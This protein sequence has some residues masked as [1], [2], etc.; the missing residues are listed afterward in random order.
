MVMT[1]IEMLKNSPKNTL[2]FINNELT[3]AFIN[4]SWDSMDPY[5]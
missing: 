3:F 2:K 4:I 5:P 1:V